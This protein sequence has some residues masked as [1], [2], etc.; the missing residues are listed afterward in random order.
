MGFTLAG[1]ML[2]IAM[3]G[4]SAAWGLGSLLQRQQ[5]VVASDDG[6]PR[7]SQTLLGKQLSI[8]VSWFR[9]GPPRA[10]GFA[11]GIDLKL[12]LPLG[13]KGALTAIGVTLLP[14]S[15]VRPSISLLDGVYLHEFMQEELSGPPG[16]VGKPLTATE[17]FEN[18]TVW[19]DA[20]SATP[21]V[22][23]CIAA[24][25]GQGPAQC[26]R[27]VALSGGI[28]AVYSFSADVLDG[29]KDFDSQLSARLDVIGA[30]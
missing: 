12:T 25:D 13:K 1:I 18:E 17:G 30:S 19:Y 16:L 21:F 14:L 9:D 15:K 22:A 23:K 2:A 4:L 3:V 28:A 26:L 11:S 5:T 29:W 24:P 10:E 7:I 8:P 27:T 6:G 20:L